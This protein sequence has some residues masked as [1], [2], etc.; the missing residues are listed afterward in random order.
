MFEVFDPLGRDKKHNV[1]RNLIGHLLQAKNAIK[2]AK[3][4]VH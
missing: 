2:T 3:G 1:W 4:Y